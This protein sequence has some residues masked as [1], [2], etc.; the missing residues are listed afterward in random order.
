VDGQPPSFTLEE[1]ESAIFE[2]C[3]GWKPVRPSLFLE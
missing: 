3:L 2:D 1:H